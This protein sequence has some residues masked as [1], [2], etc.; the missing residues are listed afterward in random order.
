M[1][2]VMK[3]TFLYPPSNHT[4]FVWNIFPYLS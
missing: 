4:T 3:S 2:Y 1:R